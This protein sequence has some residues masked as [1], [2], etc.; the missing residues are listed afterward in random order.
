LANLVKVQEEERARIAAD[1]HDGVVQMMVGSLC[2]VQAAMAHAS[3]AGP[4]ETIQEKQERARGLIRDS[5]AELRRVI[6][7]LRPITLDAA[8]LVP[9]IQSLEED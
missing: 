9:A 4:L 2:E 7:D 3:K 1:V 6:F 8:G 5:I